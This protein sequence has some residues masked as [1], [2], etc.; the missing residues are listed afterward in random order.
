MNP[1]G[2]RADETREAAPDGMPIADLLAFGARSDVVLAVEH[3][4][5]DGKALSDYD[6]LCG[7]SELEDEMREHDGDPMIAL[8]VA[9]AH[10]DLAWAWRVNQSKAPVRT[11]APMTMNIAAMVQGA[12][13][14][15]T[16][17]AD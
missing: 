14:A 4:L 3:A 17:K 13:F 2:D 7:I 11:K 5:S 15:S 12:G 8:V 10:I 16:L 9:L 1:V 6:L